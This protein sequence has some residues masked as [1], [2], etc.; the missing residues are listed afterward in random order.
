MVRSGWV[1]NRRRAGSPTIIFPSGSRLTTEGH[2]VEPCVPTIHFG[3]FVCGS[4]YATRLLV[5]PRSI[6]TI[7]PINA[8]PLRH[9][10]LLVVHVPPLLA[11]GRQIS[12]SALCFQFL[13]HV[14]NEI[15]DVAASIQ[16]F[17]YAGKNLF[18]RRL[19]RVCIHRVVP[20]SCGRL[21]LG[22]YF[23]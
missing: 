9:L 17:V 19:I 23:L 10:S 2:K 12:G 22:V 1:I 18:A 6:P 21:Q 7:F 15:T 13:P 8:K 20:I 3:C 11:D 16:Q 4:R 14:R 5:V